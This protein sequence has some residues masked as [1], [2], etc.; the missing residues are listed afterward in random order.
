MTA[1]ASPSPTFTATPTVTATATQTPTA[2]PEIGC[3][4]LVVNGGFEEGMAPWTPNRASIVLAPDQEGHAL[5]V[6]ITDPSQDAFAY[7]SA[8]QDVTI[9][10]DVITALL[11]F[12]YYPLSQDPEHDRQIVELRD[13]GDGQLERLL[14]TG[15]AS[16]SGR[17]EEAQFDL[18][19]HHAGRAIRLYFG[20]L[21]HE[22]GGVTSMYVDDVSLYICR[23]GPSGEYTI[24]L[25]S[26]SG[27]LPYKRWQ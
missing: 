20:V 8:Y 12:R 18:A 21:N 14:G 4:E 23:E 25:P 19:E 1:T 11:S 3:S 17:W 7:S 2:T 13:P 6:G 9:P 5:L 24:Y 15:P 10:A 27:G 22:G 26:I 16:D